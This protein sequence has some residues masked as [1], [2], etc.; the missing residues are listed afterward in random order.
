MT[1]TRCGVE[2]IDGSGAGAEKLDQR[3]RLVAGSRRC[4]DHE[5]VQEAP[6]DRAEHLA[7][8]RVLAR[9]APD[10]RVVILLEEELNRHG[11]EVLPD[12]RGCDAA[13]V[14]GDRRVVETEQGWDAGTV[15]VHVQEPHT[16][17]CGGQ[18][19]RQID[20]HCALADASLPGQY[21]DFVPDELHAHLELVLLPPALV[22][23][24]LVAAVAGVRVV[25][26]ALRHRVHLLL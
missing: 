3:E 11:P 4:V 13:G 5:A 18:G 23:V 12:G 7:D 1:A 10:H 15:Q 2:T 14:T 20:R 6:V 17:S 9:A 19:G 21:E 22:A 24:L 16:A 25:R 8:R 26:S